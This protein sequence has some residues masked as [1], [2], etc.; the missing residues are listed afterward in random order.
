MERWKTIQRHTDKQKVHNMK[1]SLTISSIAVLGLLQAPANRAFGQ[2]P[3]SQPPYLSQ[4]PFQPANLW[5]KDPVAW[6]PQSDLVPS[7]LRGQR[8]QYFD[9]LIGLPVALT[10]L[11][12]GS[13]LFSE[14]ASARVQPEIPELPNRALVIATFQSY[15][16][17]LSM[18]GRAIYTEATFSVSSVFQ[19]AGNVMPGKSLVLIL[20][21]G[22]VK[23]P[24]GDI[25]SFLTQPRKYFVSTGRTYLLAVSFHPTGEFFML[26]KGWDLSDGVVK[27]N[28]SRSAGTPAT[29]DGLTVAQL[30]ATLNTQFGNH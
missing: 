27:P 28:F 21:G 4:P 6:S 20:P 8:D 16:P 26:G 15:Q 1:R 22:T 5:M 23:T 11:N 25:L 18:S 2:P 10:P 29:L 30:T 13:R 3:Q 12:A 14:G 9:E 19:A 17:V 24:A 7:S